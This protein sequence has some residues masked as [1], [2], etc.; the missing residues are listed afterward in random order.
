M[1]LGILEWSTKLTVVSG[2]QRTSSSSG[3]NIS[4]IQFCHKADKILCLSFFALRLHGGV[5]RLVYH[6]PPL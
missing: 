3:A 1:T 2:R 6:V 5:L 4:I